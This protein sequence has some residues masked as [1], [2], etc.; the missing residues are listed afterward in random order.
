MFQ[1]LNGSADQTAFIDAI[2]INGAAV[3]RVPEPSAILLLTVGVL[4]LPAIR[5]LLSHRRTR[6]A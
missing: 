3:A 5:G 2:A 4:G 1:G 6:C